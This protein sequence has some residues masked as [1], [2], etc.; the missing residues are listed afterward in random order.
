M[1]AKP[2]TAGGGI[3]TAILLL[4]RTKTIS[5]DLIRLSLRLL[6]SAQLST[7]TISPMATLY[8]Y[9]Y[10]FGMNL[11]ECFAAHVVLPHGPPLSS[12]SKRRPTMSADNVARHFDV[13]M[14]ADIVG[15]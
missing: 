8:G 6:L 7:L 15:R 13:I 2:G 4:G 14:S 9:T 11:C 1:R 12:L 5:A 10:E 3:D